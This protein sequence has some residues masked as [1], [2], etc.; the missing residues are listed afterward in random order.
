MTF[1]AFILGLFIM[2]TTTATYAGHI[3]MCSQNGAE[4]PGNFL[5]FS[6]DTKQQQI[7][8]LQISGNIN[9][10]DY[11]EIP[12]NNTYNHLCEVELVSGEILNL[13]FK[14]ID[15]GNI[16]IMETQANGPYTCED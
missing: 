9:I 16:E 6:I 1:K 12:A 11:E 4:D 5:Q 8:F 15:D 10:C 14:F 7:I 3:K 2:A 13:H